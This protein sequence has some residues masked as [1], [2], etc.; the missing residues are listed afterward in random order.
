MHIPVRVVYDTE[1]QDVKFLATI[2]GAE[3]EVFDIDET[4]PEEE[5]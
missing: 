1:A 2:D 5:E 4:K 3:Q